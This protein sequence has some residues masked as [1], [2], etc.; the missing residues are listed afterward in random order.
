M[1]ATA[2]CLEGLA[3]SFGSQEIRPSTSTAPRSNAA[4]TLSATAIRP[5]SESLAKPFLLRFSQSLGGI[6]NR[7]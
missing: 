5:C 7:K 2:I 4:P 1:G 6:E 3:T